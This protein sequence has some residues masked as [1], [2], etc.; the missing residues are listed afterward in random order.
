MGQ[1]SDQEQPTDCNETLDQPLNLQSSDA[2]IADNGPP[3]QS[4]SMEDSPQSEKLT[5]TRIKENET[6]TCG[7]IVS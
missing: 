1:L 7:K 3:V 5:L 2:P 6:Q 4:I